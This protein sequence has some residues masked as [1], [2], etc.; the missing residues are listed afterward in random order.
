MFFFERRHW[1]V[2]VVARACDDVRSKE[3]TVAIDLILRA[4]RRAPSR[5]PKRDAVITAAIIMP[6]NPLA[7]RRFASRFA[8]NAKAAEVFLDR[9]R[10]EAIEI[11]EDEGLKEIAKRGRRD[12]M[13]YLDGP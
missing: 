3:A 12:R 13:Q 1:A 2:R 7:V 10:R 8:G 6:M 5:L 11:A 9:V 4:A